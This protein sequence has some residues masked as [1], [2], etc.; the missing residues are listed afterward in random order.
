VSE[1][2]GDRA[3]LEQEERRLSLKRRRLQERIDFLRG[4]GGGFTEQSNQQL[5]HLREEESMTSRQRRDLHLRI[6]EMRAAAGLPPSRD[7]RAATRER[8]PREE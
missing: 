8:L 2:E 6:D 3:R 5:R 1:Q 4:G 7:E